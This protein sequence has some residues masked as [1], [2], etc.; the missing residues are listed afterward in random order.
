[1]CITVDIYV[2]VCAVMCVWQ[3]CRES[4]RVVSDSSVG[5]SVRST[6]AQSTAPSAVQLHS[7]GHS[8]G[9]DF[10][11]TVAIFIRSSSSS[12]VS[13]GA[14]QRTN[15]QAKSSTL[16]ACMM[17]CLRK[18]MSTAEALLLHKHMGSTVQNIRVFCS[19]KQISRSYNLLLFCYWR[20][21]RWFFKLSDLIHCN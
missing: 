3:T 21:S 1:M 2:C 20:S 7:A 19:C 6:P 16:R 14:W 13:R 10:V 18:A 9:S 12:S 15:T 17:E 11:P 4:W 8:I 5:N